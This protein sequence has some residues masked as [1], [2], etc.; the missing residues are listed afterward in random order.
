MAL[1]RPK[2]DGAFSIA[3]YFTLVI[4]G[5]T[6]DLAPVYASSL[7]VIPEGESPRNE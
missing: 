5:L 7:F 3:L 1:F 6:R 4:P 2:R